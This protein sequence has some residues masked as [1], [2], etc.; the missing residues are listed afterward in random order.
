MAVVGLLRSANI[1][2]EGR[3]KQSQMVELVQVSTEWNGLTMTNAARNQAIMLAEGNAVND[4]F[5]EPINATT[6]KISELQKKIEAMPLD[7][8]GQGANEKDR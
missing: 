7:R 6:A 2:A 1:L 5:K 4:S 8:C 3:E